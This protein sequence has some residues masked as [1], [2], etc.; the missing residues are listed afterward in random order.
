MRRSTDISTRFVHSKKALAL[1]LSI[2]ATSLLVTNTALAGSNPGTYDERNLTAVQPVQGDQL[3]PGID[4]AIG[5]SVRTSADVPQTGI[6]NL[7]DGSATTVWYPVVGD[8]SMVTVDL[9]DTTS[10]SG[11]GIT[12]SGV[13]T[14][15]TFTV[16]VSADDKRWTAMGNSSPQPALVNG[17]IQYINASARG[18]GLVQARYA[19]LTVT[20]PAGSHLGI[21]EFRVFSP[22]S[23]SGLRLMLGDDLSTM[24]Q[25]SAIGTTY[26]INGVKAPLLSILRTHGTNY[27]RL[28]LWVNPAGGA[29]DLQQDLTM[30][31][32]IHA[33][34]L[35]LMLDIHYSDTWA[36]P[37]HQTIPKAWQGESLTTLSATVESYTK[38]VI[39][40]FAAQG[41]PVDIVSI[42]N[43]VTDGM[44]WPT[45]KLYLSNGTQQWT[46][47]TTLLKAGLQGAQEG[48]P[49]GHKLLTMIH[50][51]RGGDNA[52]A[53]WFYDNILKQGV[54]FDVIGLS[55][56]PWWHG[57]LTQLSQ[58]IDALAK[59]YGKPIVVVETQYPWTLADGDQ[60]T[61]NQVSSQTQ[62]QAGYPA[63]PEGQESY[64]RDVVSLVAAVPNHLG[65][66]VFYWEPAWLP[67][68]GWEPGAGDPNSNLTEFNWQGQALSAIDAY[69]LGWF[70]AQ[71]NR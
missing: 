37:G 3:P 68:V 32:Q 34:G 49:S 20:T 60:T 43:E 2:T 18:G 70:G 50:I 30:A 7:V 39:H 57:P 35:H 71:K 52:G 69:Q 1:A 26:S 31:Q 22:I 28:R 29:N 14:D 19:R 33:A 36:D 17:P 23:A 51:D 11:A 46:Q 53:E 8:K 42:G 65:M 10:V 48:N 45:G 58:N 38:S 64:V 24:A 62:L 13:A 16:E 44:L 66:G 59:K 47:F 27:V 54:Q 4:A 5:K 56:Y 6:S 40:A 55:Y 67:G 9:G 15:A 25:E 12:W 41:T 61:P 21:G 63:T